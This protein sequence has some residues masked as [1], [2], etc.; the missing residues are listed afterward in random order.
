MFPGEAKRIASQCRHYAMCKIDFLGTGLCPSAKDGNYVSYYPQ[1]RMDIY[2]AL[3]KGLIPV[4][5]RLVDISRTCTLCG[6]CDKQCYFVTELRPGKVM[7]ALKNHVDDYL[8]EKREIIKPEKDGILNQL[9]DVV[10]EEWATNDP[11]VLVSYSDDPFPL[12]SPVMPK[13]VVVPKTKDEISRIVR[14]CNEHDLQYAVRGNGSSVMGFVMSEG[15]VIDVNRMRKIEID[16]ENWGVSVEPGVSAFE[17]QEEVS[18]RGYRVNTAEPSALIAANIMCS[19]IFSLFSA[20]YGICADNLITAEFVGKAG[21][22]FT[23]NDKDSPNLFSY[24]K[25]EF[26]LPGI[27]TNVTVKLHP[28]LEDEEGILIPFASFEEA[29]SLARELSMRRIG[30][31]IGIVGEEY[32]A[33]FM[34]PTSDLAYRLK[35]I[36]SDKLGIRFFVVVIGDKYAIESIRMMDVTV[37]DNNVFRM[38]MLGLP[39]LVGNKWLDIIT[40]M[41]SDQFPYEMLG[42]EEIQPLIEAALKPSP[43]LLASA[44]DQDFQDFFKALYEKSEMTDIIWLNMFRIISSRMGRYKHVVAFILYVPLDKFDVIDKI[45]S[46]FKRIGNKYGIKNDYGFI[47]PLDSGKRAVF[48]YDYYIDHTDKKE[49]QRIQKAIGEVAEMIEGFSARVKGVKWIKY[50]LYQGFCRSEQLLYT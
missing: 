46:E 47:T 33:T 10:R 26:S 18:K 48:E 34:A 28:I 17:L 1:G 9:R 27:C 24:H 19:G 42:M 36:F 4:T 35:D 44:V 29:V 15:L 40:D 30:I 23:L 22:T 45:N 37:L 13:Y 50:T 16:E 38:L 5:E 31:A 3:A 32:I 20:A 21:E 7:K 14:I 39:R 43:E 8:K 2:H 12:A 25:K 6:I 49:I 11:A 41:E